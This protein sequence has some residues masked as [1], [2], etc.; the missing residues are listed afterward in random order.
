MH[1]PRSAIVVPFTLP[2][3]LEAIRLEH[4]ANARLG[5]PAHVTL[6]FPFVPATDLSTADA[7]RAARVVGRVPA[8]DIA[9]REARTFDP[10][11]TSE[12]AVWL[13]PEP[14]GPFVDL[15]TTL[16]AAFPAY[17]PYG[18]LHDTVIPHLTLA[19]VN[20]DVPT[21]LA[22]ARPS[23]PFSRRVAEAALLVEDDEG[24]WRIERRLAL[25]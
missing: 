23:L 16:A 22:A 8:F 18:G 20:V 4:V 15:T 14:T 6:L 19:E 2:L 24:R 5:V 3:A 21:L 9:F 12:G 11:P 17:P 1:A 10:A 13:A 7:E 25:G